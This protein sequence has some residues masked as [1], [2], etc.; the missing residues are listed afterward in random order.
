MA[1]KDTPK[2][3]PKKSNL[4]PP[5]KAGQSGN[6]KGRPKGSRNKLS[7]DFFKALSEDFEQHGPAAIIAMRNEK[8]N[9]YAKMVAGLMS[10]EVTGED[11]APL[12]PDRIESVIVDPANPGS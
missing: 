4:M 10:K 6:P 7:E 1:G 8:P 9:E 3:T 12:F 5:W 11:G 2:K